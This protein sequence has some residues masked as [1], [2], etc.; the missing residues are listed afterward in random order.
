MSTPD[1][2]EAARAKFFHAHAAYRERPCDETRQAADDALA[3]LRQID[4][5][6]PQPE[7]IEKGQP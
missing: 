7:P 3:D 6:M 4:P 2:I 1:E 5:K